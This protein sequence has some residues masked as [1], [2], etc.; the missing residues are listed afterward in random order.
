M[1]RA[2][3]EMEAMRTKMV[4]AVDKLSAEDLKAMV[5]ASLS[6]ATTYEMNRMAEATSFAS[7]ENLEF[8]LDLL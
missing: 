1:S 6:L 4:A 3:T 2:S 7:F 8:D 5:L